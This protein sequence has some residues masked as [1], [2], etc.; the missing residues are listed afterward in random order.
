MSELLGVKIF[1]DVIGM[2]RE[3]SSESVIL[4]VS[5]LLEVKLHLGVVGMGGEPD[6]WVLSDCRCKPEGICAS[7]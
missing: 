1:L 4:G 5:E 3:Q 2:G 6:P 7:G